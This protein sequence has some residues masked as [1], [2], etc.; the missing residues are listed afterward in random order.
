M[1]NSQYYTC[2]QID[3]RLLQNYLDDYNTENGT[4]LSKSQ[5]LQILATIIGKSAT[6]DN[7]VSQIGYYICDTAAGTAAKVLSV[8]NYEL[9]N[10]GSIKVKFINKNT[11]NNATLNIGSK[12]AKALYYQGERVSSTN[13]WEVNE[14]VEVY[15]DGEAYYANNVK[16]GSGDG[17]YDV[18]LSNLIDGNPT[19]YETLTAALNA[20][21]SNKRKGGISIK[22]IL[23]TNTGTEEEPVYN[24]EY[25]Q[26]RLMKTAWSNVAGD[27]QGV[28]SEPVG[29]SENLVESGGVYP[30]LAKIGLEETVTL[31]TVN[32]NVKLDKMIPVG[33]T[34]KSIHGYTGI[35]R[36]RTNSGDATWFG[37]SDGVVVDRDICWVNG[38][39]T[40]DVTITIESIS[41]KITDLQQKNTEQ[42][43]TIEEVKSANNTLA[44]AVSIPVT[45]ENADTTT[46]YKLPFTVK[47]GSYPV[48]NTNNQI[49]YGKTTNSGSEYSIT[50][51]LNKAVSKDINYIKFTQTGDNT[52]I[53]NGLYSSDDTTNKNINELYDVL[54]IPRLYVGFITTGS[55]WRQQDG[56]HY[57]IPVKAG[58]VIGITKKNGV[59]ACYYSILK[60]YNVQKGELTFATGKTLVTLSGGGQVTDTIPED[61]H[62]LYVSYLYQTANAQP[63]SI[64]INDYDL[65]NQN[66]IGNITSLNLLQNAEQLSVIVPELPYTVGAN[67]YITNLGN[68]SSHN[69]YHYTD[70]FNVKKNDILLVSGRGGA[71]YCCLALQNAVGIFTP[72]VNYSEVGVDKI[73]N[74]IY[75]A[76]E[77]CTL[78]LSA[79]VETGTITIIRGNNEKMVEMLN[80]I[81]TI[82]TDKLLTNDS[83]I[84]LDECINNVFL[85]S[86]GNAPVYS[87]SDYWITNFIPVDESTNWL[88][89]NHQPKRVVRYD[90]DKQFESYIGNAAIP[91]D[92]DMFNHPTVKYIRMV[93]AKSVV[94][95]EER[96]KVR[97]TKST[98]CQS[99]SKANKQID[100][101]IV[102]LMNN[103]YVTNKDIAKFEAD[104]IYGSYVSATVFNVDGEAVELDTTSVYVDKSTKRQYR[105]D[106]TGLYDVGYYDDKSLIFTESF[107]IDIPKTELSIKNLIVTASAKYYQGSGVTDKPM[108]QL[109]NYATNNLQAATIPYVIGGDKGFK[110]KEWRAQV[111]NY[112]QYK[113]IVNITIPTGVTL[114]ID[115]FGNYYSDKKGY[116]AFPRVNAHAFAAPDN[117]IMYMEQNAKLGFACMITIPKRTYDGVWVC[118]HDDDKITRYARH[119]DGS[120]LTN[121]DIPQN[122]P[123]TITSIEDCPI[124]YFTYEELMQ[125]DFGIYNS[126]DRF[127]PNR[128]Q[129]IPLLKD[130]LMICA[131][132]GIHPM[133][134]IHPNWTESEWLEIKA[135]TDKLSLTEK[136][137]LKFAG[138]ENFFGT[139][140]PVFGDEIESYAI[141]VSTSR[142][143]AES[144]A[145]LIET[146]GIDL[147]KVRVGI[148]YFGGVI[149]TAKVN[150]AI[151]NGMF[152]AMVMDGAITSEDYEYWMEH[153]VSEFT[154]DNHTS[155]GLN[156]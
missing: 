113:T 85:D 2:E 142:D 3:Q 95:Y 59:N 65:I 137:N 105:Y 21:P 1:Y 22:F 78:V 54:K 35:L 42:D 106:G 140:Y 26:Y 122:A 121:T 31:E 86:S 136:L 89:V 144:M 124:G 123:G 108:V 127:K 135:M 50:L 64:I 82:P 46:W 45:F 87:N 23:R 90:I 151:A 147:S 152:A 6:I 36:G 72:L 88:F 74:F 73:V 53:F 39:I 48:F 154:D 129:K 24:D 41:T 133:L 32:V 104:K 77:D 70:G 17:I 63:S 15:Y 141:D 117:T 103:A 61:G 28:D 16:G 27:W 114:F 4:N 68:V 146:L 91:I 9:F 84:N 14:V 99:S 155:V 71:S 75:T 37:L 51:T 130:F 10:G 18:S 101:N 40:G 80:N 20:V 58:D 76:K 5:F 55:V 43:V 150:N 7:L 156:W 132:T 112:Q 97:I 44:S 148:E 131:K 30:I 13:T 25:V 138:G 153:G 128:G 62:Y 109:S 47:T 33:S 69:N 11:A 29:G 49:V 93:F 143:A 100:G 134:S 56:L 79:R 83:L 81:F 57:M 126:Y 60:E 115:K 120:A 98:D 19:I 34:V 107:S 118:L 38:S 102:G 116:E 92:V 66:I 119:E 125:F 145:S 139:T 52:I 149:T 96:Y 67:K 94:S 111:L 110:Q 12:G 8:A